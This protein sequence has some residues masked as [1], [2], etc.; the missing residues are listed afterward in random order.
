MLPNL[1]FVVGGILFCIFLFAA[2]GTGVMLPDSRTHIGEMPAIGRTMMQQ[3]IAE[4]PAQ[5][6]IYMTAVTPRSEEPGR[7]GE[8]TAQGPPAALTPLSDTA[9]NGNGGTGGGAVPLV[10]ATTLPAAEDGAAVAPF[11]NV[12]LPPPRP[13]VFGGPRQRRFHRKQPLLQHLDTAI[14]GSEADPGGYTMPQ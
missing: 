6:R 4:T 12:P 11:V 2:A 8:E 10:A 5:I 13:A 9:E 14:P 7:A 1:N 3:S